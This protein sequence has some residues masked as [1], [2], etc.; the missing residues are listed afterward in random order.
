MRRKLAT[1][2]E[3]HSTLAAD[4]AVRGLIT[5]KRRIRSKVTK[6]FSVRPRVNTLCE[7]PEI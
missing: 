5:A 4:A 3:I 1:A 6:V 7:S 2:F